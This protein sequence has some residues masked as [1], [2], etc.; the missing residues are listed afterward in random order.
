M[1]GD[2]W[3]MAS[4][5]TTMLPSEAKQLA[6][7]YARLQAKYHAAMERAEDAERRCSHLAAQLAALIGRAGDV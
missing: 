7:S 5:G 4:Q 3:R 1:S 6:E 2:L